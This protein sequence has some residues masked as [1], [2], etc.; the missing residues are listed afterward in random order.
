MGPRCQAEAAVSGAHVHI[1]VHTHI[2]AY[3]HIQI[4]IHT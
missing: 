1:Y 4:Y 2:Y 3:T